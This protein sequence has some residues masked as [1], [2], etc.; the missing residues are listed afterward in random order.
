MHRRP[1]L[2][3]IKCM[4]ISVCH[5]HRIWSSINGSKNGE[6]EIEYD[7][8]P[9]RPYISKEDENIEIVGN[10]IGQDHRLSN[11]AVNETVGVDK[12]SVRQILQE[13]F[14]MRDVFS[15]FHTSGQDPHTR[16]KRL[17]NEHLFLRF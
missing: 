14:N 4:M 17:V 7:P 11:S 9:G 16:I 5:T 15:K 2:S 1:I 3:Y 12:E 6:D 8:S 10:L 13:Y